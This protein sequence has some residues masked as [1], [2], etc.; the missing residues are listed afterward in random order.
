MRVC[1]NT[2]IG[3]VRQTN[4]DDYCI[5]RNDNGDWLA[6]VCDGIGGSAAGEVASSIASTCI[7][8][9]FMKS[10]PLNKDYQVQKWVQE[11]LNR[12]NDQIFTRSLS[13]KSQRGMGTT[14]VGTIVTGRA[15][16]IFNVGDSR[17]YAD[18]R[19][20]FIQMSEDHSIIAQL[21]R[22]GKLTKEEARSHAQ[23]NTLTS[24]LGVWSVYRMDI[25]K[26]DPHYRYLLLCSDGLHGYVNEN[27]ICEIV[28]DERL[29][30]SEKVNFLIAK[31]NSAGGADNC[32]VVLMEKEAGGNV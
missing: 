17:L 20:G 18:Y 8:N 19:D 26:I 4:E 11:T 27:M 31:A 25:H 14:C 16:Y 9:A 5:A 23:R 30:L 2:D 6:L 32:T 7:Y 13:N 3:K 29:S 22:E 24:A 15:T 10:P 21:M 28:E 12:A 1:G